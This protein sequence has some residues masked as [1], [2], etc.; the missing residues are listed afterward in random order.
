MS[1]FV[2]TGATSATWSTGSNWSVGGV[3]QASPPTSADDVLVGSG[4]GATN[5]AITLT[6]TTTV[7]TADF[8]GYTGTFTFNDLQ[9][10]T[11]AG[12]TFKLI[13]GMTFTRGP[14]TRITFTS[15]SGTTLITSAGQTMG[16]ITLNGAGG[17]FQ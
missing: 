2:W 9:G 8:T 1:T 12:N 11:I 3:P 6:S 10:L 4:T 16:R 17:T 15:T 14:A 5:N 7:K 13:A